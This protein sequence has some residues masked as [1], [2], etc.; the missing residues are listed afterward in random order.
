MTCDQWLA[1][2]VHCTEQFTLQTVLV[3]SGTPGSPLLYNSHTANFPMLCFDSFYLM[4]PFSE[5]AVLKNFQCCIS[6]SSGQ[7]ATVTKC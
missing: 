1:W 3:N 5:K 6:F 2:A 4:T 7:K